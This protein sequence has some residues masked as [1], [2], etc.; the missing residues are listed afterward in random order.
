MRGLERRFKKPVNKKN[1]ISAEVVQNLV[2]IFI[3]DCVENCSISSIRNA[4]FFTLLFYASARFSDI[5]DINI[6][7][8]K[9][10]TGSTP[11]AV[12]GFN[13]LKKQRNDSDVGLAYISDIHNNDFSCYKL[14]QALVRKLLVSGRPEDLLFPAMSGNRVLKRPVSYAAMSKLFKKSLAALNLDSDIIKS[15]GLHSFRIG[16]ISA[17]VNSG[18]LSTDQLQRAGRWASPEMIGHY[19]RH[20]VNSNLLFSQSID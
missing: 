6:C 13:R 1:G 17:A 5:V 4:A 11:Y 16:A 8:V 7:Y 15:L 3:P 2:S 9:F 18:R 14:L 10:M 12:V 19:T 20:S